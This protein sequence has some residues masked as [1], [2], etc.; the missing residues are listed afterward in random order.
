MMALLFG[1]VIASEGEYPASV[2]IV[3][4]AFRP[5]ATT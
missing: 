4:T 3:R 2:V 5:V 1:M